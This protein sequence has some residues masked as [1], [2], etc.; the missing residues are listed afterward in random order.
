MRT[1]RWRS[2]VEREAFARPFDPDGMTSAAVILRRMMEAGKL[3]SLD[4]VIPD[5]IAGT[6]APAQPGARI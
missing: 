5:F 3:D 2:A 6:P 4:P 1:E